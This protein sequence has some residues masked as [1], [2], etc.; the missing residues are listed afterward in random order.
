MIYVLY[1]TVLGYLFL[2]FITILFVDKVVMLKIDTLCH[3][4]LIVY[5]FYI[6]IYSI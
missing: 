3:E 1:F 4:Y 6:L 2:Q 5:L